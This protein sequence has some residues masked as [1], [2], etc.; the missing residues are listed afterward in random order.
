MAYTWETIRGFP[1][2]VA[3]NREDL[4]KRGE[5]EMRISYEDGS[6]REG[7]MLAV[8]GPDLRVAIRGAEDPAQ[9]SL[10]GSSWVAEDGRKVTFE[11]PL[12]VLGSQ[13]F[14]EAIQEV[15]VEGLTV[16][17]ACASGGGCLLRQMSGEPDDL[18]R[19]RG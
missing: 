17:R 14:L 11:F 19:Q 10:V 1:W 3:A 13:E 6:S 16:P 4:N 8:A 9:F 15:T 5:V 12:G 18:N 7:L 2:V